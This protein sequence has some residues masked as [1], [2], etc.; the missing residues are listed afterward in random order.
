MPT[1]ADYAA[2]RKSPDHAEQ[3]RR[4]MAA[5]RRNRWIYLALVAAGLLIF[6][7]IAAGLFAAAFAPGPMLPADEAEPIPSA[8]PRPDET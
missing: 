1:D 2:L 4:W 3:Q 6:G 5:R 7:L 8:A